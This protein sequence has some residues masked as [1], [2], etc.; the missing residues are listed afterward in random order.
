[1]TRNQTIQRIAI[2]CCA[3]W[4]V[5]FSPH[6]LNASEEAPGDF[7]IGGCGGAYFLASP[8]ELTIDLYKRDRN[9]TGRTAE[10]R[11]IL[12][13]PDRQV[14]AEALIPDDQAERGQPGP[15][16][17][18]RLRTYAKRKGVFALNITV[19]QDRYGDEIAWGFRTNCPLYLIETSRGHRDERHREPIVL[20]NPGHGGDVCFMPRDKAF[21]I[22]ASGL[23]KGAGSVSVHDAKGKSVGQL[24]PDNNGAATLTVPASVSREATPWRIHLDSCQATL[25][26]DGVTQWDASDR[27]VD[28]PLWTPKADSYFPLLD[29]RWLLTPYNHTV[30]GKE[31]QTHTHAFRVHNNSNRPITVDLAI[32]FPDQPWPVRLSKNELALAPKAATTVV[33]TCEIPDGNSPRTCHVRATP[34]ECPDFTT[35]ST[36]IARNG[37]P[38]ANRQLDMPV[39]LQA[40]RHENQLFGYDPDYPT[41]SQY[42]F[43]T[44]NRPFSRAGGSI[45]VHRDGEWQTADPQTDVQVQGE[46][47]PTTRCFMTS[48]KIA[49]DDDNGIYTLGNADGRPVLFYSSD[50]GRTYVAYP[51]PG[52][53]RAPQSFDIEQPSGQN[54][55]NGPPPIVRYTRTAVDSKLRWRRVNDLDLI[56]PEMRDGRIVFPEPI[57]LS[58]KCIGLSSHS[59]IPS[60][61][62]S[63]GSKVHVAWGEATDPD[64][65]VPGVPTYVATYDRDTGQASKPA[66][67][68]YGPPAN[69]VHNSPS[70]TI[71]SRGYLHVLCGTHGQP[72]PYAKSLA[73]N[74]SS[75]GWTPPEPIGDGARQTYIGFV[76]GADDTLHV[77]FR[78]WR[79]NESPYPASHHAT[80]AYQRKRPGH[81][82]EAP[83]VLVVAPFSE[84]SIFYHRLTIDRLGRL[85]LSYDYWSTYWFYRTDHHG[86]RRALIMSSDGGDSWNLAQTEDLIG[87]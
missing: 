67:V 9:R 47:A 23:P 70:I 54:T 72:F 48:S 24:L 83:R 36:L 46:S 78:M 87:R 13:G 81:P 52:S 25:H 49:F 76:C 7:A 29:F 30:F 44:D 39:Q 19:S 56:L 59:G 84:Y 18:V 32:E 34:R 57:R 53:S 69:D 8:G 62:V 60:S 74:D 66:L 40:Y 16:Q 11:A 22:E 75:Q 73:S 21:T 35:Y 43:G 14:L 45:A 71:D 64:Q 50:E 63:R 17:Q 38:P 51:I 42:Y 2:A 37:E 55:P 20:R 5:P 31:G 58:S 1:M 6:V 15:W 28:L 27:F 61:V 3:T 65:S 85:F 33:A 4:L 26:I 12:V 10:M 86:D 68:G 80:L 82:W 77:V 79:Y 41:E